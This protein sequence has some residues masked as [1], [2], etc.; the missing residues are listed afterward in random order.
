MKLDLPTLTTT[1]AGTD[2]SGA[3]PDCGLDKLDQRYGDDARSDHQLDDYR[4]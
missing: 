4:N 1:V 3:S 2:H